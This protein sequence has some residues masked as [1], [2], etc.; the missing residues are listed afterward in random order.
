MSLFPQAPNAVVMIRPHHFSPNEQTAG[1]NSFQSSSE[2]DPAEVSRLAYEQ[3]TKAAETLRS[4][5]INVHILKT[6]AAT[7]QIRYSQIIGF[8]PISAG[9][10]RKS[11]A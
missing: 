9:K 11:A 4:H 8:R 3:V 10:F 2:F 1:D 5:G 6:K 7:R